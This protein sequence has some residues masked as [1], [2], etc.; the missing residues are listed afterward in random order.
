MGEAG[1]FSIHMQYV[2]VSQNLAFL[3]KIPRNAFGKLTVRA[4]LSLILNV[5]ASSLFEPC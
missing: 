4:V 1:M 3:F 2:C 5:A